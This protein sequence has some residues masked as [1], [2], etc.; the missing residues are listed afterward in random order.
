MRI[1]IGVAAAILVVLVLAQLL[2][3]GIAANRVRD[4]VARYGTVKSVTVKAWPAVKLL[5]KSA[6]EVDV[7]AGSLSIGPE[8]TVELL[9]EASGASTVKGGADSVREGPLVLSDVHLQKRGRS[10]YA[11]ATISEADVKRALPPGFDV[12]LVGSG[13]GAVRVRVTG[14]LF[15][16]G[17]SVEAVAK[18]EQGK[19]VVQ[20]TASF[21]AGLKVTLFSDPRVYIEGVDAR[22]EQGAAGKGPGYRLSMWASLR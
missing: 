13:A 20:P 9:S 22:P 7:H 16:V 3:P 11:Q 21:L 1:A 4:M 18:G 8:Q 15:G 12:A 6:D 14:G 2:L 10:M 5:W 17:A 19:L